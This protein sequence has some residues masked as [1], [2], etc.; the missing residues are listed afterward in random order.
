MTVPRLEELLSPVSQETVFA[1]EL[2]VAATLELPATAWQDISIGREILAVNAQLVSNYSVNALAGAGRGGFLTYARGQWLTLCAYEIFD[3]ERIGVRSA[4]GPIGLRNESGAPWTFVAGGVR[5]LNETNQKTYTNQD[6]GTIADGDELDTIN[7]IA[8]EPGDGSNLTETDTLSLVTPGI[9]GITPFYVANLIGQNEEDDP[10]LVTRA[11][12][13][14]AK[15]SPNGPGDAYEYYARTTQRP[16]GSYV[17]VNRYNKVQG[18]GTVTLYLAD[19]DGALNTQDRQY[20]FDN[21]NGNV[22]PTGFTLFIPEPT[23]SELAVSLALALTINPSSTETQQAIEERVSDAVIAYFAT[24]PV[25]GAKGQSF[26][27]VFLSTLIQ[28]IR[29]AAGVSVLNVVITAPISD[30]ALAPD[31]VP[32]LDTMTVVWS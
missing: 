14:N 29:N 13:A 24:I 9:D 21:V 31:E 28:I 7:F 25:G 26:Q 5:V 12:S 2:A 16:D 1:Q 11:R 27:G 32:I 30:I 17:G 19:P 23:C 22:V 15:A 4:T 10:E 18:N 20:V 6:G 3:T 8:D